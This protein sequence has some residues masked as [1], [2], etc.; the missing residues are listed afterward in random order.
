[1]CVA[2]WVWWVQASVFLLRTL[3]AAVTVRDR[4]GE[5]LG[6]A[7]GDPGGKAGHRGSGRQRGA[8]AARTVAGA[9][10]RSPVVVAARGGR[11]SGEEEE[12]GGDGDDDEQ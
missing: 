1:M 11:S 9:R 6:P 10:S 5:L 7:A 4:L 12:D 3:Q 2:L 8:V